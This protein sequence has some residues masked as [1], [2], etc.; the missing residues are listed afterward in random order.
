MSTDPIIVKTVKMLELFF[1]NLIHIYKFNYKLML[2]TRRCTCRQSVEKQ[3]DKLFLYLDETIWMS[4]RYNCGVQWAMLHSCL[5]ALGLLTKMV[6]SIQARVTQLECH[7]QSTTSLNIWGNRSPSVS[8]IVTALNPVIRVALQKQWQMTIISVNASRLLNH[9][10]QVK[11]NER[12][13]LSVNY[14]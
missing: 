13:K 8:I 4:D 10:E 3:H 11:C 12:C 6:G 5:M 7:W 2:I 1:Y 9:Y 14:I